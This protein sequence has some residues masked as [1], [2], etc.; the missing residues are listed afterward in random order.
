MKKDDVFYSNVINHRYWK[1]RKGLSDEIFLVKWIKMEVSDTLKKNLQSDSK[2]AR[3]DQ[4]VYIQV[5]VSRGDD[6]I[7]I[8]GL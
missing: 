2:V 1:K 4:I 5:Q 6:R 3:R 8:A 7:S